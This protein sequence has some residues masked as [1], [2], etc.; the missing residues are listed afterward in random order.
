MTAATRKARNQPNGPAVD[1]AQSIST[2][3]HTGTVQT[4]TKRR[5]ASVSVREHENGL[6][7][8]VRG[9]GVGNQLRLAAPGRCRNRAA[10]NRAQVDFSGAHEQPT[11]IPGPPVP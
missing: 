7:T 2:V 5:Y 8:S 9:Q 11:Q 10:G 1:G 3:W 6:A 4:A